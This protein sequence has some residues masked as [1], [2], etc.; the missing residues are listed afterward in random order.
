LPFQV[1]ASTPAVLWTAKRPQERGIHAHVY[2]D[3]KY[4]RDDTFGTVIYQ[5]KVLDRAELLD[6]MVRKTA[7]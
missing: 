4:L 1:W 7:S 2:K 6:D 3:G 5:G